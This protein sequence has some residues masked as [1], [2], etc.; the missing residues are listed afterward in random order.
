[1]QIISEYLNHGLCVTPFLK[2]ITQMGVLSV[3][4]AVFIIK[5]IANSVIFF[6]EIISNLIFIVY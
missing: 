6:V 5:N 1:M 2:K 3:N 4:A